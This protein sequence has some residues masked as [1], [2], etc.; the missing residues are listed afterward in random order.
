MILKRGRWANPP[1]PDINDLEGKTTRLLKIYTPV[2]PSLFSYLSSKYNKAFLFIFIVFVNFMNPLNTNC[3]FFRLRYDIFFI[4]S[5][6]NIFNHQLI[7]L[8][9]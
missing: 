4:T 6:N 3:R 2:C 7:N 8:Y 1:I 9:Q 5:Y